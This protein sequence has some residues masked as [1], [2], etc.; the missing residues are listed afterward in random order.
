MKGMQK[1]EKTSN[2]GGK[3]TYLIT[4]SNLTDSKTDLFVMKKYGNRYEKIIPVLFV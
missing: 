3:S 2:G 1:M 4:H